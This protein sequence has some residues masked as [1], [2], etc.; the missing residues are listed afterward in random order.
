MIIGGGKLV[1]G[2]WQGIYFCEFD[3][4]SNKEILCKGDG[5]MIYT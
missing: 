5:R 1:L 3:P 4:P 2:T